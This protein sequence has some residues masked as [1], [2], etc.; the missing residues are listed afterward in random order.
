MTMVKEIQLTQGKV[1]LVDDADY[2]WLNQWKWCAQHDHNN[3]YAKRAYP[4]DGGQRT[5]RMHSLILGTPKGQQTDHINSDGL[6][7]RRCNLRICTTVQNQ[8]NQRVQSQQKTSAFKGLSWHKKTKK[9]R[10]QIVVS[11]KQIHLGLF[12]SEIEAARAYDTAALKYFGEF[13]RVNF[14]QGKE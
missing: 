12:T 10:T 4:A 14:N 5:I 7:N 8:Q 9:W 2:E 13:A 6:D 1:S 11:G 3:W